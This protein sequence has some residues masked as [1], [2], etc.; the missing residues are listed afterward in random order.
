MLEAHVTAKAIDQINELLSGTIMIFDNRENTSLI[1]DLG[2]VRH[3]H[4]EGNPQFFDELSSLITFGVN[5]SHIVVME[6][7]ELTTNHF[8][9][10]ST[11]MQEFCM[12][13]IIDYD[14]PDGVPEWEWVQTHASYSALANNEGGVWDFIINVDIVLENNDD[15]PEMLIPVL[16]EAKKKSIKYVVF[17]QGT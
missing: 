11:A 4:G 10:L 6:G 7:R 13:D 12:T 16:E 9:D 17:H 5:D 8:G 14:T 3:E 1:I 2:E 15:I